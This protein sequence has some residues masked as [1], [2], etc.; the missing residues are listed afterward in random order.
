[1]QRHTMV[2]N[3]IQRY[4]TN[5]YNGMQRHTMVCNGIQTSVVF[6]QR[7]ILATWHFYN[8]SVKPEK[9]YWQQDSWFVP[10]L[11]ELWQ[12]CMS[13]MTWANT[14]LAMQILKYLCTKRITS[15]DWASPIL[16]SDSVWESIGPE[17]RYKPVLS[18]FWL[19]VTPTHK[20]DSPRSMR[21]NPLNAT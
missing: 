5:G 14:L 18:T 7:D 3:G 8:E 2:C 16:Y 11:V 6:L 20:N 1:M 17:T 9:Y 19:S 15:F 10:R 4:A 12:F 13:A 21:V